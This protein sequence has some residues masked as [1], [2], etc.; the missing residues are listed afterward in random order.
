M[1]ESIILK[2]KN[3][4]KKKQ[5][6]LSSFVKELLI[7]EIGKSKEDQLT[8]LE[9]HINVFTPLKKLNQEKILSDLEKLAGTMSISKPK[10]FKDEDDEARWLYLKEKHGF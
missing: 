4:A 5:K 6:S 3:L 1:D 10:Q 9:E 7:V 8:E 2:A